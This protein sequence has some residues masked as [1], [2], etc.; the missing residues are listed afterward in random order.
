MEKKIK[1][2]ILTPGRNKV[3]GTFS[4]NYIEFLDYKKI[5]LFGGQ[6]PYFYQGTSLFK[7][8]IIRY[9]LTILSL[10]NNYYLENYYKKIL[11]YILRSNKIDCVIAEYL[12]TGASVLEV[13]KELNIPIITN[14][15]GY[16]INIDSVVKEYLEKYR[17]LALYN[18]LIVFPVAKNMIPKLK[19][20]GYSEEKIMYSPIGARDEFFS[21]EPDY[22]SK[23]FLAIGRFVDTKAPDCT[24]KAFKIVLEKHPDAKLIF[25]G[26]GELL[27]ASK[28]LANKLN[29]SNSINF[30]GWIT[31][32]E[33]IKL[34]AQSAVFVQHSVTTKNG[35]SEGTPVVILE[36]SAAG[37]AIVS[38][39]HA[40]IIDTVKENETG[41]LVPEYDFEKMAEKMADLINNPK[42]IELLGKNG[43][44]FIYNN[45]SMRRHIEKI[46]QA[47]H[48]LT[49]K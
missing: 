7:Q 5:V 6:V 26:D 16:E 45:F 13:C 18:K 25:A 20:L 3:L 29:I 12:N 2:A 41:F 34:M 39:K 46:N 33:Q 49:I 38:T 43:R 35:D 1:I 48:Q 17:N 22:H 31:P 9:F 10:K 40:G 37:L 42:K 8:K 15:L 47:I 30:I 4:R 32:A 14:V 36:A 27:N 23:T 44:N 11:K 19:S 21:V 28:D 24:I